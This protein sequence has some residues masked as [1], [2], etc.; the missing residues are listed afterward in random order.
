[1]IDEGIFAEEKA[2]IRLV[3]YPMSFDVLR[4]P[5]GEEVSIRY[6]SRIVDCDVTRDHWPLSFHGD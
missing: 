1:M 6:A 3:Q 2:K 5:D 4:D